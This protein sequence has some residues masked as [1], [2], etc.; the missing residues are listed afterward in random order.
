MENDIVAEIY[1][2]DI[3]DL[4]RNFFDNEWS[5]N[6]VKATEDFPKLAQIVF[7]LIL[8]WRGAV[9]T[10]ALPLELLEHTKNF[11][12]AFVKSETPNTDL[13]RL[14]EGI[15]SNLGNE[16]IELR[17]DPLILRRV[18]E[19]IIKTGSKIIDL[20]RNA[21]FKYPMQQAW[22][23]YLKVPSYQIS[24]W[25]SQRISFV[26]IYNSYA[27]FL[28]QCVRIAKQLSDYR[29]RNDR[30]F[31]KDINDFFGEKILEICWT[32]TKLNIFRLVRHSLSHLGGRIT[33][34]LSKQ[35]HNFVVV[36]N[37]IQVTPDK[38]K[39]LYNILKKSTFILVQKAS[40]MTQYK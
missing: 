15:I 33:P 2:N 8:E 37:R 14:S 17:F 10:A 30:A 7:D 1:V 36:N 31:K 32:N 39:E 12:D 23:D 13:L 18:Q 29:A 40:Q 22:I 16:I 28:T 6:I 3:L 34:K 4:Y 24:I 21:P 5:Q 38:T 19:K 25:G 26:A 27:N 20:Y 35:N 11:H 9:Y